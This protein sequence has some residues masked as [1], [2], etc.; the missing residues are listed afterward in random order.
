MDVLL[1]RER[2][3]AR[4]HAPSVSAELKLSARQSLRH[5]FDKAIENFGT[6]LVLPT[7]SFDLRGT[8]AAYA[9]V[10]KNHIQLNAV[11]F[12]ENEALFLQEII[13]HELSHLL[14]YGRHGIGIEA[15]GPEW[16]SIMCTLGVSP[17]VSYALDIERAMV[18]LTV[19]YACTCQ[20]HAITQRR[21]NEVVH[22]RGE[23]VLECRKCETV[24]RYVPA[25]STNAPPT[26]RM[27]AY[28]RVIAS[29]AGRQLS[30]QA[31]TS[32]AVCKAFIDRFN[33]DNR[34]GPEVAGPTD[35]P[36]ESQLRYAEAL[37][38]QARAS[39]PPEVRES[40]I[41]LSRWID[42]CKKR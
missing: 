3:V 32:F 24:L 41:Q 10:A 20:I 26:Q 18:Q 8:T 21:H 29:K 5:Y 14:A 6:A 28:A 25:N 35:A 23:K 7:I 34:M 36:T 38:T 17:T 9:W 39:I 42:Q 11:L 30:P 37:A 15:H 27:V 40:R 31:L 16:R 33:E 13:P 12:P 2:P 22:S 4:V 19:S 1:P